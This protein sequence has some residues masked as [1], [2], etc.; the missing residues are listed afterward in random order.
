M[1]SKFQNLHSKIPYLC[2]VPRLLAIDYGLKR[3]GLAWTD[4]NQIIA[5]GIGAVETPALEARV[6]TLLAAEPFEGIVLGY[7]TRED[8]SET[9]TTQPVLEFQQKL[10]KAHPTVPVHLWDERY[11]TRRAKEALLAGGA[12]RKKRRDKGLIDEVSATII[13]Q[14]FMEARS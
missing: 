9:H 7:P 4:P 10:L 13:L 8:G 3:C 5:T 12:G 1:K 2:G 14:E 11:T 6:N